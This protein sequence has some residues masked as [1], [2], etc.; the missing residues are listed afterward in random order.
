[1]LAVQSTVPTGELWKN[2]CRVIRP[3]NYKLS[4]LDSDDAMLL[5]TMYNLIYPNSSIA[6]EDMSQLIK[7]VG[8]VTIGTTEF[9][10][11]METRSI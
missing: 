1:M 7:K 5:L 3:A 6:L 2:Y 10:S 11:K 9:G 8:L 4:Y